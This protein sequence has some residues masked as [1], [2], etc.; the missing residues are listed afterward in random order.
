MS[1]YK[2]Y[3]SPAFSFFSRLFFTVSGSPL[4]LLGSLAVA[5]SMVGVVIMPVALTQDVMGVWPFQ[6]A[7]CP[8]WLAVDVLLS[9]ASILNLCLLSVER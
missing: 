2:H 7:L 1:L 3:G 4:L 6:M 5:D 9:S 8:Y